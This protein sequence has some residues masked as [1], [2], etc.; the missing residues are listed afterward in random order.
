MRNVLDLVQSTLDRLLA[1][2]GVYSFWGR[3]A[4]TESNPQAT[5][6]VIYSIEGDDAE[7]SADGMLYYRMM[8]VSLQYYIKYAVAR[9]YQGRR[10]AN[11]RMD[12][13]RE[14]MRGAGFGCSGGWAEIGDVDDIGFATF[15][16]EYDIPRLMIK[17]PEIGS[18]GGGQFNLL[19]FDRGQN[20]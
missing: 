4:D 3:R 14:V 1:D 13:M 18:F 17:N 2:E 6:Y 20:G 7:V 5:E 12:A 9:T 15:R 8:T 16:S 10:L 11:D 19:P